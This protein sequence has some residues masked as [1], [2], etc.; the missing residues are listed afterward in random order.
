M[1]KSLRRAWRLILLLVMAAIA[2][3]MLFPFLWMVSTSVKEDIEVFR[4]PIRWIPQPLKWKN[5]ADVWTEVPFFTYYLN[6]TKIT[7]LSTL[8]QLS[9]CA[10]AAYAF[11]RLRFRFKNVLFMGYL[12][13][14]MV[15]WHSIM[16]PQ[17]ILLSRMGLY[18][19]HLSLILLQAFSAFGIFLL[20]QFFM[21]I[22]RELSEAARI[23]GCG[24]FHIFARI[25]LPLCG[26]GLATLMV[27]TFMR[28]WNDYLPPLIYIQS[29]LKQTIQ[30]GLTAFTG[31]Y[32]MQYGLTMAGTVSALI[33]IILLLVSAEKF[34]TQGLVFSGIKN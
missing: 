13:T 2:L 28:V 1:K 3:A 22:P 8:L 31:Q 19:T 15:P 16:I 26:P 9:V 10:T 24:E 23:D 30:I 7:V 33:P 27:F 4:Y 12:S 5:Y 32:T 11:A 21:G 25:I 29:P 17:F 14:L 6:T 18:N 20:R 34:L